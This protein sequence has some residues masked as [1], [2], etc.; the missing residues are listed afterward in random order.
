MVDLC[1]YCDGELDTASTLHWDAESQT[2]AHV[3]CY[4]DNLPTQPA[5]Q[6]PDDAED[7]RILAH[8]ILALAERLG[9]PTMVVMAEELIEACDAGDYDTAHFID[10]QIKERA[11]DIGTILRGLRP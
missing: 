5:R 8:Q 6:E 2:A 7:P 1:R 10:G 11:A 4:V 9:D 3:E